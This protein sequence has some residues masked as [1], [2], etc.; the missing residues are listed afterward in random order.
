MQWRNSTF[1][2]EGEL[3]GWSV[4]IKIDVHIHIYIYIHTHINIIQV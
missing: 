2:K 3:N 1:E 4:E